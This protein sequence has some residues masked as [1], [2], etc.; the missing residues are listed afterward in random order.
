MKGSLYFCIVVLFSMVS[1]IGVTK[2]NKAIDNKEVKIVN[3]YHKEKEKASILLTSYV[4]QQQQ[5]NYN[6][7]VAKNNLQIAKSNTN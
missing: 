1:S 4:K 5:I 3:S 2:Q 6:L 7:K